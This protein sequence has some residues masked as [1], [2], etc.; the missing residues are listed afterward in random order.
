MKIRFWS[1]FSERLKELGHDDLAEISE[2][3]EGILICYGLEEI[4][5]D[6][7]SIRL[8]QEYGKSLEGLTVLLYCS[9]I[10]GCSHF[11]CFPR[12][13]RNCPLYYGESYDP[14]FKC[15]IE[16]FIKVLFSRIDEEKF[17]D[18]YGKIFSLIPRI[19]SVNDPEFVK[20]LCRVCH[21]RVITVVMK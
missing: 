9:S 13:K 4:D 14:N 16:E 17:I 15:L 5:V 20:E 18:L 3:I 21:E 8:I 6:D 11:R 10:T 19:E 12:E 1:W 7:R 2:A